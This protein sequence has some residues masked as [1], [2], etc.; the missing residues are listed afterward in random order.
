MKSR[1]PSGKYSAARVP[2]LAG[3]AKC[4]KKGHRGKKS[5]GWCTRCGKW[6][7]RVITF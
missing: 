7:G 1:T 2:I 4:K 5:E 3:A 6:M